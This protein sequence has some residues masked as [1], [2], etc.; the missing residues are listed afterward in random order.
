MQTLTTRELRQELASNQVAAEDKEKIDTDPSP[1]MDA[2]RQWKTH[3]AGVIN[4]D[5]NDCQRPEKIETGLAIA[6]LETRVEVTLR[7]RCRFGRH[8]ERTEQ[9]SSTRNQSHWQGRR[10]IRK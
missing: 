2:T 3:E 4:D 1:S 7:R 5:E 9:K 10:S 6:A 8:T